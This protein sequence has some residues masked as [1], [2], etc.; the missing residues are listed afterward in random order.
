VTPKLQNSILLAVAFA[1][2]AL[3]QTAAPPLFQRLDKNGDGKLTADEATDAAAFKAA[4]KDA[5]GSVTRE[6]L[7]AHLAR[8]AAAA[9]KTPAPPAAPAVQIPV[10]KGGLFEPTLVPGFSEMRDGMNG[11][12]VADLNG[13]GRKDIVATTTGGTGNGYSTEERAH[14]GGGS[15]GPYRGAKFGLFEG[16]LRLPAIVS[17]PGHLPQGEVRGQMAHACD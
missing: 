17:W 10:L 4:D 12:A 13:D 3:A 9:K 15:S 14:F 5:D 8:R 6:E 1:S 7:Q 2:Q 11:V 16:G